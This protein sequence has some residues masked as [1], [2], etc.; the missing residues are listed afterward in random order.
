MVSRKAG[1]WDRFSACS[2]PIIGVAA[3]GEVSDARLTPGAVGV[4]AGTRWL[5]RRARFR[6]HLG[7]PAGVQILDL[8]TY[9]VN[10]LWVKPDGSI[11]P[12]GLA[13]AGIMQING[14]DSPCNARGHTTISG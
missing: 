3:G 9:M 11:R 8:T 1:P 5:G 13:G 14:C 6:P 2:P 10:A 4:G 12:F 7:R